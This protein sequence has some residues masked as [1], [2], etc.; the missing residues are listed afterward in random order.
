METLLTKL[1]ISVQLLGGELPHYASEGDSGADLRAAS[2]FLVIPGRTVLHKTGL[3]L[4]IPRHPRHEDGYRWEA[5]V[6]PRSGI[7]Y[8][9]NIKIK[10]APGTIDNFF[11]DEVGLL[12]TADPLLFPVIDVGTT[13]AAALPLVYDLDGRALNYRKDPQLRTLVQDLYEDEDVE[14]LLLPQRSYLIRKG[15]RIAQLVFQEVIR[16]NF[17]SDGAFSDSESR[18]GGFGHSGVR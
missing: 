5:Q 3:K 9:T 12:L 18:G 7:S 15:D 11:R 10:N 14:S 2:D 8:K 4:S 6:R 16:V 1:D 17:L 13:T